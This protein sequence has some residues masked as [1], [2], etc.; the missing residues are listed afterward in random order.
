[1]PVGKHFCGNPE[2]IAKSRQSIDPDY[3]YRFLGEFTLG[4]HF[5]EGVRIP[6]GKRFECEMADESQGKCQ[7]RIAD[8]DGDGGTKGGVGSL[9]HGS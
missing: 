8:S 2:P 5:S 3:G 1:M 4:L 9:E 7:E 6:V